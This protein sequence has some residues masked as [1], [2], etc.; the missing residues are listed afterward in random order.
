MLF[1]QP[2]SELPVARIRVRP[3]TI[4]ALAQ[5]AAD[6]RRWLTARWSWLKP[7]T[8]PVIVAFIGMCAV[9]AS[10]HYLSRLAQEAPDPAPRASNLA[11]ER[12]ATIKIETTAPGAIV[13]ID[14]A[15]LDSAQLQNIQIL[16]S[17]APIRIVPQLPTLP[18][19]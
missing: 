8:V 16:P 2:P 14:G 15:A 11:E 19:P 6:L 13:T 12:L 7:R 10:A 4:N 17:H 18:P 5:L 9:L 1:D 3:G